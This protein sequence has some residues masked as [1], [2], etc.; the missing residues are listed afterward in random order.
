[1]IQLADKLY[2]STEVADLLGVSLRSVYRYIEENKLVA[3]VKTATGR[4]RFTKQNI[5]DF[6]YPNGDNSTQQ[7]S[8][9]ELSESGTKTSAFQ[10]SPLREPQTAQSAP[11]A[12][13]STFS[14]FA[15][16][17]TPKNMH[18]PQQDI[19][20]NDLES[21]VSSRAESVP[22]SPVAEEPVDWLAKFR[23]A[24]KRFEDERTVP[25]DVQQPFSTSKAYS[26]PISEPISAPKNEESQKTQMYFYRSRL[27]GLKDIAQTI[28]KSARNSGL[29]YAFTL[30]AGLSLFKPIKPFSVLHAYVKPKDLDFFE[31]SLMLVP[32]EDSNAQLCL[33]TSNDTKI[34]SSR[35]EL[36]GLYVVSK[37]QLSSDISAFADASL[38]QESVSI[39]R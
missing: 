36:H 15:G 21:E 2:T 16:F 20:D 30:A 17:A 29:S 37:E 19:Q 35:S 24:A 26:A 6:L 12:D 38:V 7:G 4:H 23:E 32:S 11:V 33:L 5:V 28:D 31:R 22:A 14:K 3:E 25:Q 18:A 1:M 8:A 27:G 39:L 10:T 34:Y 9:K 13:V